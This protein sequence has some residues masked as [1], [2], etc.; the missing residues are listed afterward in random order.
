MDE[1][2]KP[3]V[4]AFLV[5]DNV[6]ADSAT[7]KKTIVGAFTH[8]WAPNFPCRHYKLGIYLCITDAEGEYEFEIQLVYLNNNQ[9]VGRAMVPKVTIKNRLDIND[10]GI[11]IPYID[12]PAV[13]RYEF[14]LYA[15][16]NF[17]TQKDFNVVQA[18]GG[19]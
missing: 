6:I 13:G 7:G 14:R 18:S 8:L 9:I 16:G 5:C 15:N 1:I 19:L 3:S 4:Q 10:Y 17:I 12:F 2:V 11:N